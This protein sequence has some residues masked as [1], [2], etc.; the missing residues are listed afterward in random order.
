MEGS[1]SAASRKRQLRAERAAA[2]GGLSPEERRELSA[3]ACAHAQD[4]LQ[5]SGAETLLAY[6][7][8]RSELDTRP[9]IAAAWAAG[10]RVLLP[11]VIPGSASMS[12][13]EVRS[14]E[15]LAPG[16]YGIHEPLPSILA[17]EAVPD[18]VLVP[19]LAF[20]RRGGRLGYGQGYYDRLRARWQS[21]APRGSVQPLWAGLAY[22]LQ[23]VTEVP[24]E[25]HDAFM[26]MLITENGIW[27]CRKEN[28]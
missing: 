22:E 7:P 1:H 12:L 6:M 15:E 13:H 10:G 5:A 4:W 26:D 25:P 21:E 14:W 28:K 20:D 18:A 16:A 17:W 2:R 8:L 11:R 24:M 9:L 3:R 27:R 19:G 23:L